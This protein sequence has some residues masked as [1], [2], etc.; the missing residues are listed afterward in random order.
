MA[1]HH[2]TGFDQA[3]ELDRDRDSNRISCSDFFNM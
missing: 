2:E 3:R 1:H